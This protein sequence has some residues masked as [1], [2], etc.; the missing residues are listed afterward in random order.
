[1][2][3]NT[4]GNVVYKVLLP[5]VRTITDAQEGDVPRWNWGTAVLA[6]MFRGMCHRCKMTPYVV[7]TR[8]PLLL[9]LWSYERFAI[10]RPMINLN[11]YK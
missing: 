6:T 1:M 3:C 11:P 8:C 2:F 7:I 5:Y 10:A 9:Q 4:N